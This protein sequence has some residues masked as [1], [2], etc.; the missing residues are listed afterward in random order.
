MLACLAA[1]VAVFFPPSRRPPLSDY[2]GAIAVP[3][4]W[5]FSMFGVGLAIASRRSWTEVDT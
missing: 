5:A 1:V 2:V 3:F 4:G